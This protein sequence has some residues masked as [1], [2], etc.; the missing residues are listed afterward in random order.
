MLVF[1]AFSLGT[2]APWAGLGYLV[3]APDQRVPHQEDTVESEWL[4]QA[5]S[6]AFLDLFIALGV[7]TAITSIADL[8]PLDPAY[9]LVLGMADV[10]LRY[11]LLQRREA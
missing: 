10:A 11:G 6:G 7:T 5:T 4:Q 1:L 2:L 8:E 9:F 3:A